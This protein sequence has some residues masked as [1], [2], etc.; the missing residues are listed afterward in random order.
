MVVAVMVR[1]ARF[2]FPGCDGASGRVSIPG[3][4]AFRPWRTVFLPS[5]SMGQLGGWGPG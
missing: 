1:G 4:G 5:A 3:E 2:S